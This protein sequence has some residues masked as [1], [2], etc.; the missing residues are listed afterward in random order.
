MK[1]SFFGDISLYNIDYDNFRFC[2]NL[3]QLLDESDVNIGNLEC[4]LTLNQEKDASL[5]VTMFADQNALGILEK[6]DI[7]SLANNH[8]RDFKDQGISDTLQVL[9]NSGFP[10]FGVGMTQKEA[11]VPHLLKEGDF[12]I[13]FIGTT[14]FANT[15]G[16]YLGTG[17]DSSTLIIKQ[18]KELKL[19][20]YFVCIFPHWG[21]E[22]VRIPSPR[23][24]KLAHRWIDA[25]ADIIIGSHPHIYQTIETY[26]G[27][28]IVYSLGNFIFHSSVFDGL[29][30][31]PND[32]RLKESFAI[33]IDIDNNFNYSTNIHGYKT[34]DNEV[35]LYSAEEN[36]KLI[37][38][39]MSI[40]M[41]H[42]ESSCKY[43]KK[44][45]LQAYEIS[46]QNKKVRTQ[47]QSYESKPL[48]EKIKVFKNANLQDIK[49]RLAGM[50][51]SI[52]GLK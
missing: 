31:I 12:K 22:Y 37:D 46:Q 25:G 35:V 6:F 1:L 36:K 16:T 47:Y 4:P 21:Y 11:L 32:P 17:N 52:F 10:Y 15:N 27:K 19:Q 28:T 49:N 8:I 30:Y 40:S 2:N 39:V 42:N 33:S 20:G 38:D 44:Y 43:L 51:I 24:R 45:Y 18:I 34:S 13:A 48:I 3:K 26:K 7:F 29:S 5:A 50:I 9:Q 14:R 41:V 23:E